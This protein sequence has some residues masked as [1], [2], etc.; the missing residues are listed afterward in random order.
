MTERQNE[1]LLTLSSEEK[2]LLRSLCEMHNECLDEDDPDGV[3][4]GAIWRRLE[5]L[6]PVGIPG[7]TGPAPSY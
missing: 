1:F 5:A 7:P 2:D 4:A 3:L 6:S